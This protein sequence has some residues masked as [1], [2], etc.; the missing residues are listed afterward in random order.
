MADKYQTR[1]QRRK[2]QQTKASPNKKGKRKKRSLFKR[3]VLTLLLLCIVGFLSGV[4][5]FAYYASSAPKLNKK[6]LTD[7]VASVIYDKNNKPIETIGSVNRTYVRYDE[8]PKLVE[9][10]VLA[11]EDARFYKHHGI[12]PIRLG[13]AVLANITRGF[14]AEGGSTITQQVVKM[15]YLSEQKTLKRK[16]QEAWLSLQLERQYT[17]HE[18]LE[19]YLNKIYMGNGVHGIA[20]A[21]KYYYNKPLDQLNLPQVAELAGIQQSPNNYNPFD[22]PELAEKRRNIVL[23]LMYQHDKIS[24]QE[25]DDA[26]KVPIT[27]GLVKQKNRTKAKQKY[28]AF[29]DAVIDEVNSMG[30][31]NVFTDGLKIY[32]TLD[33]KAQEYTENMLNTN[34]IV[35]YPDNK[36]QAGVT[37]LDTKTGEIRAIGGSRNPKVLRGINYAIDTK[38]ST[39]ST[40]KPILDYG[41]AIEYNKWSTY[42]QLMDTPTNYQHGNVPLHDWDRQ[43]KG[44]M[45][46]RKALYESRNIP[47]YKA[48][49]EVGFDN[50]KKFSSNLGFNFNNLVESS[51]IGGGIEVSSMQL[52]GAYAAFGNNGI[53]NKPHTVRKIVLRDGDTVVKN[54]PKPKIAMSDYTAYMITDMLKDVLT[55]PTG[56]GRDANVPGLNLA[57]KTGTTNYSDEEMRKWNITDSRAVPDAWFAGYNTDYTCAIWTGY[58]E[59]KN[60]IA[61]GPNQHI[62]QLMFKNLISYVEQGKQPEDFKMPAS[63][64]KLPVEMGT[65]PAQKP[66]ALTPN[67]KITYELFVRGHEEPSQVSQKYDKLESPTNVKGTYNKDTNEITLSWDHPKAKDGVTF[68]ISSSVN[69]T[70]ESL[71]ATSDKTL[72]ISNAKPGLTYTFEITA[73]LD[74]ER[75]KPATV[76]VIIPNPNQKGNG[77]GNNNGNGNGNGNNNDNGNGNGNNNG[78]DNGNGNGNGSSKGN[79]NGNDNGSDNG[80]NQTEP[81]KPPEDNG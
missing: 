10:A 31:Y 25:M 24:K 11:T 67:D 46:M 58:P 19:M 27:Y 69:G 42:H 23:S 43:Y 20:T 48:L 36:F 74:G 77:N 44:Q 51:S 29:V 60:Y 71:G 1:E 12:D 75:S 26:Q 56:T 33:P 16:A 4:A 37:L 61:P 49:M 41:P 5:V 66:S 52:A 55:A 17:K 39:G 9:D 15:S 72:T 64:V 68:E 63:V 35:N 79:G 8:L 50:A 76:T 21:A 57:G 6:M 2:Q 3:L 59:R 30:D 70:K 81:P 32:T 28:D 40:I 38:R 18:I 7:P 14:G 65:N 47:A 45:S 53:Y 73:V 80:D 54:T 62:A 78:N 13:G 22:N 34:E